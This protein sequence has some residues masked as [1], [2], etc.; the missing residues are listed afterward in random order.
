MATTS[1]API[2]HAALDTIMSRLEQRYGLDP[3]VDRGFRLFMAGNVELS[4]E[5]PDTAFVT[6]DSGKGYWTTATGFCECPDAERGNVCKHQLAV[7]IACQMRAVAQ[8]K[9]AQQD[10][11]DDLRARYAKLTKAHQDHGRALIASGVRPI[12]D[13]FY[14]ERDALIQRIKARLPVATLIR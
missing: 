1:I 11:G 10:N 2:D 14:L 13:P 4:Q 6:G 5:C 7:K 3:R 12:D 8:S 9:S